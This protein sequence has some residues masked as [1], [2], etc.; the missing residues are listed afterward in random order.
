VVLTAAAASPNPPPRTRT[1]AEDAECER[2]T[3]VTR[4]AARASARRNIARVVYKD[5][6]LIAV[7]KPAGLLTVPLARQ[8]GAP[9]VQ[10]QLAQFLRSH[11]KKRPFP[12]HRIDRDTSGLVVFALRIDA[13]ENLKDQFLRHEP[14]RAYLAVVYGRPSP[15]SGQW[16]DRL[17]W[18]QR[19]LMQ[20]QTSELDPKGQEAV[21]EYR[22]LETFRDSSLVEVRLFTGKRNQIRLQASIRGHS[23]V[24]ERRYVDRGH[25][26]RLI[27]FPRQALHAARLVL[28]H[29]A[30]GQLLRLEAPLPDD[31]AALIS[32]LRQSS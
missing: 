16:R 3:L 24:G 11:G 30:T 12:V 4:S 29:P 17:V 32:A 5:S 7:D 8:S 21:S 10:D 26:S 31:M 19:S 23:L 6:H 9:S 20:K 25:T 13:Q 22:V 14:E 15:A 2:A 1:E 27:A 18:D 28:R